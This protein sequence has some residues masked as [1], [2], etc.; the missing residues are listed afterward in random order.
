[1][2]RDES[3]SVEVSIEKAWLVLTKIRRPSAEVFLR[4]NGEVIAD[5][6]NRVLPVDAVEVGTYTSSVRLI[7]LREDVFHVWRGMRNVM[8]CG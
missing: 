7:D 3:H 1:L 6:L 4:P 5:D 2:K 8:Q